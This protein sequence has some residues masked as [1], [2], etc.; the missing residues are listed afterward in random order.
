MVGVAEGAHQQAQ[1]VPSATTFGRHVGDVAEQSVLPHRNQQHTPQELHPSYNSMTSEGGTAVQS[2]ASRLQALHRLHGPTPQEESLQN[3][4]RAQSLRE[5]AHDS[6]AQHARAAKENAGKRLQ[7]AHST[8][9]HMRDES[10][11]KVLRSGALLS[12]KHSELRS[13]DSDEQGD[14]SVRGRSST[15]IDRLRRLQRTRTSSTQPRMESLNPSSN[16]QTASQSA[17]SRIEPLAVARESCQKGSHTRKQLVQTQHRFQD[18]KNSQQDSTVGSSNE[19]HPAGVLGFL[20]NMHMCTT[21]IDAS[22]NCFP[23]P[24]FYFY[25]WLTE[26]SLSQPFVLLGFGTRVYELILVIFDSEC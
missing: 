11:N 21:T 12:Q 2:R 19:N 16:S 15:T 4:P 9:L 6:H 24:N 1:S 14:D 18:T 8:A 23:A 22:L 7:G 17:S 26:T 5:L 25:S 10:S 3:Q 20:C 13:T